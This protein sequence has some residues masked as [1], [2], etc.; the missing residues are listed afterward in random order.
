MAKILR[1]CLCS[2]CP[3]WIPDFMYR[4]CKITD[5]RL[6]P[7]PDKN[8]LAYYPIPKWCPLEDAK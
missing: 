1:I 8:K 7:E 3:N 5:R 4:K 2:Q 6:D